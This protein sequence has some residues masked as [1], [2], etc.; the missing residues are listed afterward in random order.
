M[1]ETTMDANQ[2]AA[3]AKM[4]RDFDNARMRQ[5]GGFH[6]AMVMGALTMWGAAVTWAQVTGW[7]VAE[8]VAVANALIA[9]FVLQSTLH[10]W[11][12]FAG[13]RLAGAESPVLE[14]P[15]K[16][17][18]MFDF[19]MDK[20]DLRQFLWMSWG[21]IL[22]P[23]AVAL[24]VAAALPL[25]I[26]SVQVLLATLVMKA[27]GVAIF[28]VPIARAAAQSGEPGAELAKQVAAG[29]LTRGRNIGTVVGLAL[30]ALLLMVV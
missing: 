19:A 13:A 6:F 23:W 18:F 26:L 28:E 30:F 7:A 3:L 27:V 16:H 17:F 9:A 29:G 24:L 12:H 25:S 14:E 1:A 10:E 5:I 20:N 11:G 21:G 8:L 22:A 4:Q 2:A 15:R